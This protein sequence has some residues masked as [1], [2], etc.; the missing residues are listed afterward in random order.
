MSAQFEIGDSVRIRATSEYYGENARR[1]PR[2]TIGTVLRFL[3]RTNGYTLHVGWPD[4]YSNNYRPEDL[5]HVQP[6]ILTIE[7]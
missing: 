5:E 6:I 1:N 3:D 7:G 2:D 4:T